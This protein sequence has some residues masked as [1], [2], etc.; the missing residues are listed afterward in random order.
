M[1]NPRRNHVILTVGNTFLENNLD[2]G[3]KIRY[4]SVLTL[5]KFNFM[6]CTYPVGISFVCSECNSFRKLNQL[7]EY[8]ETASF[9]DYKTSILTGILL[10]LNKL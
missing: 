1:D 5:A 3:N 2:A 4:I 8:F 6:K 7:L 9:P 10:I